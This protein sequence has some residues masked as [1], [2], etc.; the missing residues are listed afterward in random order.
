MDVI[1]EQPGRPSV[2]LHRQTIENTR[3]GYQSALAVAE[4]MR[5]RRLRADVPE[6]RERPEN[7]RSFDR[8]DDGGDIRVGLDPLRPGDRLGEAKSSSYAFHDRRDFFKTPFVDGKAKWDQH[9]VEDR[10]LFVIERSPDT[11]AM[12]FLPVEE[13]RRW[14]KSVYV[15]EKPLKAYRWVYSCHRIYWREIDLFVPWLIMTYH[16]SLPARRLYWDL[17]TKQQDMKGLT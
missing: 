8:F 15:F 9:P 10:P 17:D 6:Y 13:T 5:A 7:E 16:L 14:W 4:W 11:G 12:L 1:V 3:K 2:A